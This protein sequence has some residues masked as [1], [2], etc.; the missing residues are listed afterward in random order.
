MTYR[1]Q[2]DSLAQRVCHFLANN[3]EEELTVE[4]IST[5]FDTGTANIHT[6]LLKAKDTGLLPRTM[7]SNGEYVYRAGEHIGRIDKPAPSSSGEPAAPRK[8]RPRATPKPR[9]QL[10]LSTI[11]IDNDPT[12]LHCPARLPA[13]DF[14]PTLLKLEIGQSFKIDAAFRSSIAKQIIELH[15]AKLGIYRLVTVDKETIRAGRVEA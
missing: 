2:A 10:D 9:P 1:P 15:K 11:Q 6:Q 14:K 13:N 12:L 5:K 7:N 8:A 3:P 4:D